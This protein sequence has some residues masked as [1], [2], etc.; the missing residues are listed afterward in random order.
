M[1]LYLIGGSPCSGKSTVAEALAA[2]Y[3]LTY[4]KVDDHLDD[5][6]DRGAVA[7]LPVCSRIRRMTA[8]ETWMR[9]PQEQCREELAFYAEISAMVWAHLQGLR[10]ERVVAEGAAFL[11]EV[12]RA[13]SILPE[14]Y[15]AITPERAFQVAHY[16]RR[17][18][19]PH[20]L[21][22]CSDPAQAF[23]NWMARDALFAEEVRRQCSQLGYASLL[24]DGSVSVGERLRQAAAHFGLTK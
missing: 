21:E 11:P 12:V 13:W 9:T 6:T 4:F 2:Q 20:V 10:A 19:V 18:W 1:E 17:P 8:E 7:G 5:F 15:I 22:G 16:S 23:A 14:R 3:G 24:T